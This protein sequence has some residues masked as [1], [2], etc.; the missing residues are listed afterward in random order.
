MSDEFQRI[1]RLRE[2]FERARGRE[3]V[4]GIGD[5]AAVLELAGARCVLSIDVAVESVH[6]ERSFA[7][8]QVLAAR[9]FSAALSDLAAMA[10]TPCAA[11][12]SLVLPAQLSDAELDAINEGLA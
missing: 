12:S 5:E 4:V 3:V 10:A 2:R 8:L 11:L 9:A 6:F 1:A 7:P